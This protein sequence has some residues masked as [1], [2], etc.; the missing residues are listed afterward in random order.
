MTPKR[1]E[2]WSIRGP[3]STDSTSVHVH[4]TVGDDAMK[5]EMKMEMKTRERRG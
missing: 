5:K 4:E 2:K 3:N 1:V